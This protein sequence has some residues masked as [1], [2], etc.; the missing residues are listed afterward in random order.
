MKGVSNMKNVS[1]RWPLKNQVNTPA[2]NYYSPNIDYVAP[3]VYSKMRTDEAIV[4]IG[5]TPLPANEYFPKGYKND[6]YYYVMKMSRKT[7][8]GNEVIIPYIT[9]NPKGSAY[10]VDNNQDAFVLVRAYVN[11]ETKVSSNPPDII[12]GHAILFT[13]KRKARRNK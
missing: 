10:G 5:Q 11:Q 6:K 2:Y 12:W 1:K 7:T 8:E 4:L 13:K 9:G 3:G